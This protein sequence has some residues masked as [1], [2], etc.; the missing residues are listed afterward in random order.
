MENVAQEVDH[1][2]T[3]IV[4]AGKI[5][6]IRGERVMLDSDLAEIYEV[7]TKRINEAVARNPERFQDGWAFELSTEETSQI[8]KSQIATSS[9]GG[10]RKPA[11]A[12][13]EHGVLMLASVLRSDRAVEVN[14][15]II[16]EFV[17]LRTVGAP[18]GLDERLEALERGQATQTALLAEAVRLLGE[19]APRRVRVLKTPALPE[20]I[21]PEPVDH[22]TA[23]V[24]EYLAGRASVSVIEILAGP[25]QV[26]I[27]DVGRG[28]YAQRVARILE[29]AGWVQSARVRRG[30]VQVRLWVP[31]G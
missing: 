18:K 6:A 12:F 23:P 24:R 21:E 28:G 29:S 11:Q 22:W 7:E 5:Q 2:K 9:W 31:R 15:F 30:A 16:A 10:R 3:A 17:R 20:S 27:P 26:P 4:V 1:G 14:R 13:T 19:S 25:L 8:L